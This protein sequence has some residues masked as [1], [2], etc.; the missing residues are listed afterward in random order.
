MIVHFIN[1]GML[2]TLAWLKADQSLEK[3]GGAPAL[4]FSQPAVVV[5]SV[6]VYLVR[7]GGRAPRP[8][9]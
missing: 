8:K 9:T 7:R 5:S 6:G 2:V 4:R 3:L 1:N